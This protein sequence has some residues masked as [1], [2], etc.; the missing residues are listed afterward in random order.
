MEFEGQYLRFEDY[1]LIGGTLDLAPFNL[2]EFEA[3][4]TIDKN[5]QNRL[6]NGE[7]IPF[8]VKMCMYKLVNNVESYQNQNGRGLS[9][10]T[11]GSYSVTYKY[12]CPNCGLEET[13]DEQCIIAKK[14]KLLKAL[15]KYIL[16]SSQS[17]LLMKFFPT[18][19]LFIIAFTL[20]NS[21][22]EF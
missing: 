10:E 1:R 22:P 3:R 4:R 12:C 19:I 8:E 16:C 17:L 21:H 2:I 20:R 13:Y 9:S 18:F 11:V 6:V 15:L 7:D 5:T 14:Q